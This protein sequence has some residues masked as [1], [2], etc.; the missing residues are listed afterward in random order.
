MTL[1]TLLN[2]LTNYDYLVL[3]SETVER[4]VF[5]IDGAFEVFT[6]DTEVLSVSPDAYSGTHMQYGFIVTLFDDYIKF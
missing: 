2:Y 3:Q 5:D 1:R 4:T 6:E